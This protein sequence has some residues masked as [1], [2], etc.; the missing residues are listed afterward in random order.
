[1]VQ[2]IAL[3]LILLIFMISMVEITV[4]PRLDFKG[5][6]YVFLWYNTDINTRKCIKLWKK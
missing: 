1:M 4:S 5:N 6:D 2:S 3:I